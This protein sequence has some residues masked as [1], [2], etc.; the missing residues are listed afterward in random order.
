LVAAPRDADLLARRLG[1]GLAPSDAQQQAALDLADLG[2]VEGSNFG[3]AQGV[4]LVVILARIPGRALLCPPPPYPPPPPEEPVSTASAS[5]ALDRGTM[6]R[7][8]MYLYRHV[9]AGRA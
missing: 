6:T 1:V 9:S 7:S 3:A 5:T 2:A 8:E 4:T